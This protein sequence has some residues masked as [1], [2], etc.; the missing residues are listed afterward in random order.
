LC[1]CVVAYSTYPTEYAQ[2]G[3]GPGKCDPGVLV[4]TLLDRGAGGD[5]EGDV[6]KATTAI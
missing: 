1:A 6:V 3:G 2:T 5:L 4:K